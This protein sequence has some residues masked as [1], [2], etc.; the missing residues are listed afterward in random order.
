MPCGGWVA[1][2]PRESPLACRHG[3]VGVRVSDR[4]HSTSG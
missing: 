4:L 1:P 2:E 3:F